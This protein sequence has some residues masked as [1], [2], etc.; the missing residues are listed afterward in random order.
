MDISSFGSI[1]PIKSIRSIK[2]THSLSLSLLLSHTTHDSCDS[3]QHSQFWDR[4]AKNFSRYV[5]S[6]F[7]WWL[8]GFLSG[9]FLL[10]IWL[11]KICTE[12]SLWDGE[13]KESGTLVEHTFHQIRQVRTHHA[14]AR[15]GQRINTIRFCI[16]CVKR[17]KVEKITQVKLN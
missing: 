7:I 3:S 6:V 17:K 1:H 8:C 4:F 12:L 15:L 2:H 14:I 11:V 9:V 10:S 5:I 13:W 16:D